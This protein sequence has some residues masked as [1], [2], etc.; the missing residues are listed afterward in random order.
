MRDIKADDGRVLS[1][2]PNSPYWKFVETGINPADYEVELNGEVLDTSFV[3]E[4]SELGGY[5][6]LMRGRRQGNGEIVEIDWVSLPGSRH[7]SENRDDFIGPIFEV[8]IGKVKIFKRERSTMQPLFRQYRDFP[9]ESDAIAGTNSEIVGLSLYDAK[10]AYE[11]DA[12]E[13]EK[14]AIEDT[15]VA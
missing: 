11:S 4:A 12:K 15:K 9:S 10:A 13:R 2:V 5:V 7:T 8:M 3:V 6:K 14:Q 1:G